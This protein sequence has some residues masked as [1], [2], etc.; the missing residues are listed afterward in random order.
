MKETIVVNGKTYPA[1]EITF[2]FVCELE[3]NGIEFT[4]VGTRMLP[5]VRCYIAY[6]M[7]TNIE[8]AGDVINQHFINGGDF[9]EILE[10]FGEK[11]QTSDFFQAIN[12][13]TKKKVTK[14]NPKKKEQE[15]SE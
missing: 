4:E 15:V 8:K 3:M 5:A 12:E 9:T 14:S 2:N 11:L 10:V 7:G 1:K 13:T 6:C